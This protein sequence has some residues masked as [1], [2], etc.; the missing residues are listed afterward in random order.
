MCSTAGMSATLFTIG[1]ERRT[2]TELVHDL[3]AA[4]V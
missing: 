3:A 1:Y 2:Q 4:G